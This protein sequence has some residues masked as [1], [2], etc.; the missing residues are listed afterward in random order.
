MYVFVVLFK[1]KPYKFLY[2]HLLKREERKLL[3]LTL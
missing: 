2:A 1:L 3:V